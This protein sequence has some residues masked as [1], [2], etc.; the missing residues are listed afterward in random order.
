MSPETL[1]D[2]LR[3]LEALHPSEIELGLDRVGLVAR[4]LGVHQPAFSVITVA[5]TNGKGSVVATLERLFVA[6]GVRAGVYTSPHLLRFN[7]RV[8]VNGMDASDALLCDAFGRVEQARGDTSL[9]YFEFTTLAALVVFEKS[10]VELAVLEVGLGGRLDAVNI[11]DAE[12]AVITR[13]DIDHVDWLGSDRE[14]IGWEKAGILRSGQMMVCADH[15][16][17]LSVR[18]KARELDCDCWFLGH[19][20]GWR[21][22][23]A[24]RDWYGSSRERHEL[25]A[26]DV[27]EIGLHQDSVAAAIQAATLWSNSFDGQHISR[28]VGAV[29]LMGRGQ[30]IPT[31]D[32]EIWLDVAHNPA[33]VGHMVASLDRVPTAGVTVA[34]FAAM[35]D[36][37]IH[38]MIAP[39]LDMVDYWYV[40]DLNEMDRAEKSQVLKEILASSG[41]TSVEAKQSVSAAL[42]DARSKLTPDSRIVV[43]GSFFTVAGALLALGAEAEI[44][45]GE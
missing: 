35:S 40:C 7:E 24:R 6:S 37:D 22:H 31:D 38:G 34:V 5:G 19:D 8:R 33:A 21:I 41:V 2:W 27:G 16:P 44:F 36:K 32:S 11:L 43:F 29:S 3:R 18:E 42:T 1:P 23:G 14:A 45:A 30:R 25:L 15:E 12:I 20:F 13:V 9:T 17:P 28:E 4:E 39:A 26:T 10:A